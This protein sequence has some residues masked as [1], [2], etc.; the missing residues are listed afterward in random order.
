MGLVFQGW[1]VRCDLPDCG[2]TDEGAI[3]GRPKKV[4]IANALAGGMLRVRRKGKTMWFC[5]EYCLAEFDGTPTT[6]TEPDP[7]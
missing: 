6:P 5:S 3:A 1:F 7:R 2:G 4:A